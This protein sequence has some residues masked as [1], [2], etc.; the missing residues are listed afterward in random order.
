MDFVMR[1]RFKKAYFPSATI[2]GRTYQ[3]AN[4]NL[5]YQYP[6]REARLGGGEYCV[7]VTVEDVQCPKAFFPQMYVRDHDDEW[8]VHARMVPVSWEKEVV[9]LC[10]PWAKTRPLPQFLSK[11]L[12]SVPFIKKQLWYRGER[13]PFT[14]PFLKRINPLACP[15]V[16]LN[17]GEELL[18]KVKVDLV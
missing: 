16:K 6:V 4:T 2:N 9:K 14:D 11:A 5:Y 3:H 15:I 17:Q 10:N 12:L 13:K 7:K 1:F 8:V 18:W